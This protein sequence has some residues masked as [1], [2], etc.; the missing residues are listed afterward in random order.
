MV[1]ENRIV[2]RHLLTTPRAAAVAGILSGSL[3]IATHVLMRLSLSA[4][5]TTGSVL[6]ESASTFT[7]VLRLL[8]FAGIFFLWFIGVA[9]DR[10]G[11]WEDKFFSTIFLGSGLLYLAMTFTASAI[12]GGLLASYSSLEP[13]M[14]EAIF[15]Y[16]NSVIGQITQVYSVRMA[17]VFM[18]SSATMWHRTG[19]M[20]RWLALLTYVLG[21]GLLVLISFSLWTTLIFPVWMLAVSILIL[22]FNYRQAPEK[23]AQP[24]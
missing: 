19:V 5:T 17:A 14:G 7:I 22:I 13:G 8:P 12:G 6:V 18:L 11:D 16:T 20:P 10:L 24:V 1:E 2:R 3:F 23:K 4:P 21:L 15:Q 9:R